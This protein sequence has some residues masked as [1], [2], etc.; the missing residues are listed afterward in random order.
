MQSFLPSA[1]CKMYGWQECNTYSESLGLSVSCCCLL[2]KESVVV[3]KKN[4]YIFYS[5][6]CTFIE[7]QT[8]WF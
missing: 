7:I 2:K 1:Y 6:I 3:I 4:M 5:T 8:F